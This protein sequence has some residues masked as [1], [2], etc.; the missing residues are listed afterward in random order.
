MLDLDDTNITGDLDVLKENFE[1][2]CLPL[3]N[4]RVSG[5]LQSLAK[6]PKLLRLRLRGTQ[7]SGELVALSNAKGL[8]SL[9]LSETKVL[10][11]LVAL[12]NATWL[13]ELDLSKTKVYGDLVALS[14]ATGLGHLDLSETKVYGDMASFANLTGLTTLKLS[15]TKVSGDFSVILQW[16]KIQHLGLSGSEVTSHPTEKWRNCCE[17]LKTLDLAWSKIHIVDGFLA[18]LEP[19]SLWDGFNCPFPAL[20]TLDMTGISLNITVGE[21]LRP[22]IGC[23]EV[24]IFKAADCSL[25]GPMPYTLPG[26]SF[27]TW[28]AD[29]SFETWKIMSNWPLSQVLQL[30]DLSSN[31]VTKVEALPGNCRAVSFRDNAQISFGEDVVKQATDHFV[32]L[33][34]RN[35][36]FAHPSDTRSREDSSPVFF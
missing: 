5:N 7:V 16:E 21:L 34:L 1:L 13:H 2:M 26:N 24:R 19:Y 23:K 22:F 31:N 32:S 9:D 20:T 6:A 10:G 30:L 28:I 29:N 35:A 4:T 15:S 33:D 17:R 3:Q 11:D 27:E 36:T 8:Y 14:N 12:S 18:N 25:T